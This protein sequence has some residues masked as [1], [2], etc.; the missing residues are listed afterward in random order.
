M[1][2]GATATPARQNALRKR[3]GLASGAVM[4]VLLSFVPVA[5]AP[6]SSASQLA[7]A[8]SGRSPRPRA[9]SAA[10]YPDGVANRT[11]PSRM[12]PPGRTALPGYV[13]TYVTDFKGST[14]PRGWGTFE[15]QPGSDPGASWAGDHV[16]VSDGLLK[17]NTFQS[18]S[19]G[20]AWIAG[21]VSQ[22]YG[23]IYGAF[24]V[25]SRVTGPGPTVVQLLWP[26]ENLWPPEIDF[27]ETDGLINSTS[28]TVHWGSANQQAQRGLS[29][30]M[31]R[32]HTWGVIW[33]PSSIT[34]TVDGRIWGRVDVPSEIPDIPMTL[35]LDQQT[36]CESGYACP[37]SP[38]SELVDWVAEYSPITVSR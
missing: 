13:R 36:W 7:R 11:E 23:R 1:T 38:Q 34:Y 22:N 35:D 15:G 29:I 28:A 19:N 4:L 27:D 30:N 25:R 33:T 26:T 3:I 5:L 12:G 32:W 2:N 6:S 31:T 10:R 24:F 17:L 8:G 16:V 14:L 20:N 9:S 18:P 37:T 21:G